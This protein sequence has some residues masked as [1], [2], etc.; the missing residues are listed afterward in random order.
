M[1]CSS[2]KKKKKHLQD[3]FFFHYTCYVLLKDTMS[4]SD[5][6]VAG[7]LQPWAR[8]AFT[9]LGQF[10]HAHKRAV[11]Y[12]HMIQKSIPLLLH[13]CAST[14][15][16]SC[17]EERWSQAAKETQWF[18]DKRNMKTRSSERRGGKEGKGS[19]NNR[20]KSLLAGC[21]M[22]LFEPGCN[23]VGFASQRR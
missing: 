9:R 16:L 10:F 12:R 17:P 22:W 3:F 2:Q 11:K 20:S 5:S 7:S 1:Y 21:E 19:N 4:S 6:N 23:P 18:K 8:K 14:A 13:S 15:R